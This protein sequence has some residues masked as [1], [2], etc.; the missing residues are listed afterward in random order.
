MWITSIIL[1]LAMG[2]PFVL[3]WSARRTLELE[4]LR[5]PLDHEARLVYEVAANIF[6]HRQVVISACLM[7]P[8]AYLD[9]LWMAGFLFMVAVDRF[10]FPRK[11]N[12]SRRLRRGFAVHGRF[13]R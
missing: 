5:R 8:L 3:Q 7:F 10:A 6:Q 9:A 4:C 12:V 11:C 1:C 13:F 2:S